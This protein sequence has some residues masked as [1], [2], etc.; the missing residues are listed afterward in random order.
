MVKSKRPRSVRRV[1]RKLATFSDFSRR[2]LICRCPKPNPFRLSGLD[3][4]HCAFGMEAQLADHVQGGP[5]RRS[6]PGSLRKEDEEDSAG[7]AG[8]V[9]KTPQGV[10]RDHKEERWEKDKERQ[11]LVIGK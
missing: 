8:S 4:G 7:R 9:Q 2:E 11:G 1:E 6:R 5:R 3:A 10:R